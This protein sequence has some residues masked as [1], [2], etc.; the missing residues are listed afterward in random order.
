[1][2]HFRGFGVWGGGQCFARAGF[3]REWMGWKSYD[4]CI[5]IRD[6]GQ[7]CISVERDY[8]Y[9]RIPINIKI[10]CSKLSYYALNIML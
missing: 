7:L 2:M 1:M 10:S 9:W 5:P 8:R 6:C 3:W 4:I